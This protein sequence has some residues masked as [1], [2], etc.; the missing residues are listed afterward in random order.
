MPVITM[1]MDP[2]TEGTKRE[3]IEVLTKEASRITGYPPAF[4]FVYIQEYPSENIGAGG[5]TVKE[6]KNQ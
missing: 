5:K 1:S 3:L 4:F 6:I 2:T